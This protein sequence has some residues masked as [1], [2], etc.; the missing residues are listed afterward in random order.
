MTATSTWCNEDDTVDD[1]LKKMGE[2]RIRRIP[3]ID[4]RKHLVGIVSLGDLATRQA[5]SVDRVLSDVSQPSLP[6]R[7]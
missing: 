7:R 5:A 1:V 6:T 3:I 2:Q 4:A